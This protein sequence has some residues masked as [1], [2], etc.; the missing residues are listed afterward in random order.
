[1]KLLG[2]IGNSRGFLPSVISTSMGVLVRHGGTLPSDFREIDN[3]H[4][5]DRVD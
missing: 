3:G 4:Q 5:Q 1:L 2:Q